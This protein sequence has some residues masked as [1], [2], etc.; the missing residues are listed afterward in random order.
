MELLLH[1][2]TTISATTET[3]SACLDDANTHLAPRLMQPRIPKA[4]LK[5]V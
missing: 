1:K 3:L 4:I 2:Y 5:Y